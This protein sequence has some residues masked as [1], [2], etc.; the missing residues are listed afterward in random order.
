MF[1]KFATHNY[2]VCLSQNANANT[3][4]DTTFAFVNANARDVIFINMSHASH[5]FRLFTVAARVS[6]G[7]PYINLKSHTFVE[8]L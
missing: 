4:T 8:N 5:V 2:C 3:H 7:T 1:G 6:L